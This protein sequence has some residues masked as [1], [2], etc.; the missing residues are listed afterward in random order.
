MLIKHGIKS[1]LGVWTQRNFAWYMGGASVSL[2]G[3]WAQRISVA[4][5]AWELTRSELWLGL[6]AF[7]DLF[8]TV[9]ITPLAGAIADRTNRLW[10]SRI[11]IFLAGCQAFIL[12]WMA[13]NGHLTEASDVWWLFVLS[14]FLGTVMA[15]A[16]AARLSMVPLLIKP[17]FMPSALANDAAIFNSARVVGPMLA[18]LIISIWNAGTAFLINGFVFM[19]FVG[20]LMVVKLLRNENNSHSSGN[21]LDDTIEGMRAAALHQ[22]IRPMLIVLSAVAIGVKSF[23]DLL[24]AVSDEVFKAGVDGFAQLAAAGGLGAVAAAIWL[25]MRGSLKGLTSITLVA[26]AIGMTG[27]SMLCATDNLWMGL[28]GSFLGGVAVTLCGTG[29]Q[30]LMQNAVEGY[31]RGRIMSIYGMLHRGA[32]ALGSLTMGATAEVLGV[33]LALIT[34]CIIVCAPILLWVWPSRKKI[35]KLLENN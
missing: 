26:M 8:P 34:T 16:T 30:T 31:L 27:I 5:L 12:A 35:A 6:I 21:V 4:W 33:Q 2:F 19:I 3:M 15:F 25:A 7:A 18:A 14:L 22:G 23:F 17:D 11:S 28:F 9:I 29:T 10:M 32:P 1:A 24:P 13:L 20:C